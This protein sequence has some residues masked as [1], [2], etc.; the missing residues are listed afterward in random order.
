MAEPESPITV[1]EAF[2]YSFDW[3]IRH[4]E[5]LALEPQACC[6][7]QGHYN[8]AYELWYFI[9]SEQLPVGPHDFLTKE[10][11]EAVESLC[12]GVAALPEEARRRTTVAQ[13]SL[14]NMSHIAWRPLREEA[15][16][17]VV[18][19]APVAK[20]RDDFLDIWGQ[21]KNSNA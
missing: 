17:L 3:F 16:R 20:A 2:Y 12:R 14:E 9:R 4:V 21:S 11:R 1:E 15:Q 10:Q 13:E 8:V 19:L 7:S 18:L 6:E 5:S